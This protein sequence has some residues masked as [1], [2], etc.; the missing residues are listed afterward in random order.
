MITHTSDTTFCKKM[1]NQ[2][3]FLQHL[4]SHLCWQK[5]PFAPFAPVRFRLR[6]FLIVGSGGS[7]NDASNQE[8]GFVL[9]ILKLT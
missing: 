3:Y 7:C 8:N 6:L 4:T 1:L 9:L 2:N 5:N